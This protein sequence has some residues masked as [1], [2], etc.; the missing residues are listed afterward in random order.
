MVR[1]NGWVGCGWRRPAVPDGEGAGRWRC[2]REGVRVAA[3]ARPARQD[4]TAASE[5]G[6]GGSQQAVTEVAASGRE[7]DAMGARARQ[8]RGKGGL[9][10][11]WPLAG[12]RLARGWPEAGQRLARG[13]PEAGQ[14]LARGWPEADQRLTRG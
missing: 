8:G 10:R 5:G 6:R 11:G 12:Q 1:I 2:V 3:A 14:G 9:T 4:V 13:W 7:T